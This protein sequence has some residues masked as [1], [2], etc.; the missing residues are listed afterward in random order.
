MGL[1][2]HCQE[3]FIDIMK[4]LNGTFIDIMIHFLS[5]VKEGKQAVEVIK[6]LLG[7][8]ESWL[9]NKVKKMTEETSALHTKLS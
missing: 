4:H 6:E 5:I 3:L 1:P 9:P 2:N 7:E 8:N